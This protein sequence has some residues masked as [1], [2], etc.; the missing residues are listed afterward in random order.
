MSLDTTVGQSIGE[1]IKAHKSYC[2]SVTIK[3]PVA[4]DCYTV[5][6]LKGLGMVGAYE[7]L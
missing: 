2:K 3:D 5:E 6:Q 4:T 7:A 1:A